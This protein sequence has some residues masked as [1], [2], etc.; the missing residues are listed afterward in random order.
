MGL[1]NFQHC[2]IKS[3][4]VV[5]RNNCTIVKFDVVAKVDACES[6][7]D[8]EFLCLDPLHMPNQVKQ[9]KRRL[10]EWEIN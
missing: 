9:K 2:F 6:S 4:G 5:V 3:L 7:I 8:Y 1:Y 10:R